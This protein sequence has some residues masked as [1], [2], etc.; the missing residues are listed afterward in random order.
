[1]YQGVI[2]LIR[3]IDGVITPGRQVTSASTKQSYNV[4]DVGV[5]FPNRVSTGALYPG[6]VGYLVLG[7]RSAKEARVGD[8]FFETGK[9]VEPLPGFKAAKPMVYAGIYPAE[10]QAFEVFRDAMEK[11][12]LNDASVVMTKVLL[13]YVFFR[14]LFFFL[15]N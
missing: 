6:Q 4:V 9:P 13:R 10:G 15:D 14:V 2:C 3:V 1:M 12:T 7:M 11:L 5:L 8:T